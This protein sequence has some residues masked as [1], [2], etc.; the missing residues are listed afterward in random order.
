MIGLSKAFQ[1]FSKPEKI[2]PFGDVLSR[3]RENAVIKSVN[4]SLV[5]S[6]HFYN[7]TQ[8]LTAENME[9]GKST[10]PVIGYYAG[11]FATREA[12]HFLKNAGLMTDL[13]EEQLHDVF[14]DL[15]RSLVRLKDGVDNLSK[16]EFK[17]IFKDFQQRVAPQFVWLNEFL[18]DIAKSNFRIDD[19]YSDK[20]LLE[21][22]WAN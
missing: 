21:E 7:S 18:T 8:K 20:S 1:G 17:D 6:Q 2:E 5:I 11:F 16:T 14:N 15:N 19:D 3:F 10:I 22:E 9:Q 13:A 4:K 12:A